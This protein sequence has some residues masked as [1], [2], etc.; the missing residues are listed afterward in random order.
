MS[1]TACAAPPAV[2]A[3][4]PAPDYSRKLPEGD[5]A[6]R[7]ITEPQRM[8]DL[9]AAPRRNRRR[10]EAVLRS[11]LM[12][13]AVSN[14]FTGMSTP[15]GR[16]WPCA[17]ASTVASVHATGPLEHPAA[18]MVSVFLF[19]LTIG[20]VYMMQ[21]LLAAELFGMVSF[22]TVFGM[23]HFLTTMMGALGP[24]A[25]GI[26]F[27]RR[28]GYIPAIW[29]FVITPVCAAVLLGLLRPPAKP[30]AGG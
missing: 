6:L 15:P 17:S 14:P 16:A 21:S 30:D 20:N 13:G 3:P 18:M 23:L 4:P 9:A 19:G 25:L 7:L 11:G 12:A 2:E 26:L 27:V 29:T 22:A 1:L 24:V 8:P 5:S 10:K 28:G